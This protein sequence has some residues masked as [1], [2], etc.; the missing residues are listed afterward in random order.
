[1]SLTNPEVVTKI[2]VVFVLFLQVGCVGTSLYITNHHNISAIVLTVIVCGLNIFL[3]K[4][5]AFLLFPTLVTV[6]GKPAR[7]AAVFGAA[8]VVILC[9]AVWQY[10]TISFAYIW[11][12][13]G[14]G[15]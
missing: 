7:P 5:I 2:Y 10:H 11:K 6:V 4:D 12:C 3:V 1:M 13:I 15:R 14:L 8:A 9:L